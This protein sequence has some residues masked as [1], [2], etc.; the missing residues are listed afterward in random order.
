MRG[1]VTDAHYHKAA[2][3][4]KSAVK[5]WFAG[6]SPTCALSHSK[7]ALQNTCRGPSRLIT[8]SSQLTRT[9]GALGARCAAH[10]QAARQAQAWR[11]AGDHHIEVVEA[12]KFHTHAYR[13]NQAAF[14][15]AEAAALG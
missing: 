12:A 11:A 8:R 4:I 10:R 15:G 7:R 13:A 14:Q 5:D 6:C 9:P 3:A 2:E 1:A